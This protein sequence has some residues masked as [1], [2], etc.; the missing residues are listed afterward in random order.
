MDTRGQVPLKARKTADACRQALDATKILKTAGVAPELRT[1]NLP[2]KN[3]KSDHF[4]GAC[5]YGNELSGCS[6][7]CGEF[8]D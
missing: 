6:I 8:L 1:Q 5:E 2:N 4:A 3:Q 7:K